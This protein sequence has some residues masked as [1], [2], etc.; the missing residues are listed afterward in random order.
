M[1]NRGGILSLELATSR[2]KVQ[3]HRRRCLAFVVPNPG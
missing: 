3:V 2:L 1:C